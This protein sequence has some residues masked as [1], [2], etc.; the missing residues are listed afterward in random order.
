MPCPFGLDIPSILTF[1][2][3][4]ITKE[5]PPT[6]RQTLEM[7]DA[8]VPDRLRR[9]EYC[10]GCDK[11]LASCPEKINISDELASIDKWVDSLI[12]EELD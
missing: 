5:R 2:N 1:R 8:A 6:T 4:V 11:C 10:T 9:A 7:Y 12:E 3:Q